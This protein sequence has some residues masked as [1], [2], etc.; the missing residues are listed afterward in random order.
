MPQAKSLDDVVSRLFT[1]RNFTLST[2]PVLPELTL[3]YE[4]YGRLDSDG[5]NAVLLTHGYSSNHH[6]AG[7]YA[8]GGAP[9]GLE[10]SNLGQWDKLVGPGKPIDTTKLFVVSSNMLGSAYGSTSPRSLDPATGKPFGPDFPRYIVADIVAA[11][12]ALLDH[13]GV[14]HLI[15]V[16][17]PSYGGFQAFQW[18]VSYPDFM[19]GIVP[20]V[21][22]PW[23][24][25]TL[26][27]TEQ[28]IEK[29]SADPNWNGGHYYDRGGIGQAMTAIRVATLKGYGLE[30]QLRPAHPDPVA[31][32]A[33]VLAAAEPWVNAYDGHSMVVL[34][35]A[36]E[37]F[38]TRP[39]FHK[40]KARVLFVISNTD[41]L[42]PPSIVPGV[43]AHFATA[44]IDARY[45]EIDTE[46]GHLASGPE[47]DQW[48]PA[49]RE[50]ISEL[51]SAAGSE[52]LPP[53]GEP[54]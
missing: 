48:G 18:A 3:A 27:S 44:R 34:R 2:G 9:K 43:M 28:L 1:T 50:F 47:G 22:A 15:A 16:A 4:T 25:T 40:I 38:D 14:K 49:L 33:A 36:L 39:H 11:Q 35:R 6:M 45:F 32:E 31:L 26:A 24:G 53:A 8:K 30:A 20:V 17:G 46:L 29:F 21:T 10:D 42:F 52:R 37:G 12:K 7:R 51:A 19:H 5:G 23:S 41:K 13:L 54:V